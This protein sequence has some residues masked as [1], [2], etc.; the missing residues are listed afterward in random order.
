M[1]VIGLGEGGLMKTERGIKAAKDYFFEA[2][3]RVSLTKG[4][5]KH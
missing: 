1:K 2:S 3:T 4:K 5:Q